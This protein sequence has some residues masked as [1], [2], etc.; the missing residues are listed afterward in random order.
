MNPPSPVPVVTPVAGLG[1]ANALAVLGFHVVSNAPMVA[2]AHG[3]IVRLAVGTEAGRP[4]GL[5]VDAKEV[6]FPLHSA[7]VAHQSGWIASWHHPQA[8]AKLYATTLQEQAAFPATGRYGREEGVTGATVKADCYEKR[9]RDGLVFVFF[10][11]FWEEGE[12]DV[13]DWHVPTR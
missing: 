3:G 12:G 4:V 8:A 11:D 2:S 10:A 1:I 13:L 9:E 7:T 6:Q 5:N